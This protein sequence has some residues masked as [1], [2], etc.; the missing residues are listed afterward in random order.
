MT[1][2][3]VFPPSKNFFDL[4]LKVGNPARSKDLSFLVHH[5]HVGVLTMM[6]DPD[7]IHLHLLNDLTQPGVYQIPGGGV[8]HIIM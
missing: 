6:V 7:I 5:G 8:Q 4:G 3:I 1:A 2:S